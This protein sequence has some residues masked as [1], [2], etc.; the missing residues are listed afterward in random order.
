MLLRLAVLT[1]MAAAG[2]SQAQTCTPTRADT[3]RMAR[4]EHAWRDARADVIADG[5]GDE[6]RRLGP[7]AD[8]R[9]GLNRPQPTPGRYLCRT[10]KMGAASEGMLPYIAYGWFRCQVTLSPGGDLEMRKLTGSQRQVGLI[11][12]T[13]DRDTARF[14]GV[15]Q[16]GDEVRVPKYGASPDS[17]LVGLVQRVGDD[18]WRIAFPWPAFESKLDLLELKRVRRW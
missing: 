11:C 14:V 8:P 17:D 1:A 10:I 6:L 2:A 12:P 7:L 9:A 5:K 3:E 15:L 4:L 16:L 13:G 18:R